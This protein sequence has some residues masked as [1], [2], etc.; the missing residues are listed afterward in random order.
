MLCAIIGVERIWICAILH[1]VQNMSFIK[2]T[3]FWL[4]VSSKVLK[5]SQF[6]E[7][8]QIEHLIELRNPILN[9]SHS[10]QQSCPLCSI[11]T[12]FGNQDSFELTLWLVFN[13][14]KGRKVIL[15]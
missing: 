5:V 7:K 14:S 10:K 12:R 6:L 15:G 13:K 8:V 9:R 3:L 11:R 4:M 1:S 2:G